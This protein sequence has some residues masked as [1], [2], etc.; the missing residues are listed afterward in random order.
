MVFYF[1]VCIN[2]PCVSPLQLKEKGARVA[3]EPIN[4]V[5]FQRGHCT[6]AVT[7]SKGTQSACADPAEK[8]G[9][10]LSLLPYFLPFQLAQYCQ[11]HEDKEDLSS[12]QLSSASVE[13][14]MTLTTFGPS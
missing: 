14:G 11:K 10:T 9:Q 13:V 3:T 6:E 5:S 2:K 4:I 7:L 8:L 12:T 1:G